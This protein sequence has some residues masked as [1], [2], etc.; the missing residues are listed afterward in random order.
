MKAHCLRSVGA[1]KAAALGETHADAV[2][3]VAKQLRAEA[4]DEGLWGGVGR[5]SGEIR[6][7]L[8]ST[9]SEARMLSDCPQYMVSNT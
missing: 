1:R 3:A 4:M 7:M 5:G 8:T 9:K 6:G 2:R